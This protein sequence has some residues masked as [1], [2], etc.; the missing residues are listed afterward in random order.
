M[1][2]LREDL[3]SKYWKLSKELTI[4]Q[5]NKQTNELTEVPEWMWEKGKSVIQTHDMEK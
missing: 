2:K 5:T 1:I 3:I 4:E